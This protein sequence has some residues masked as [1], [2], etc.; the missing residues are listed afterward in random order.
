MFVSKT[1]NDS[2]IDL[3][4]FPASKVS[5]FWEDGVFKDYHY[6]KEVA[7]EPQAAQVN[8]FRHQ[9]TDLPPRKN[10]QKQHSHKPRS[11]SQKR[12]SSEHNHNMPLHKK[13][14]Y[15]SNSHQR[16]DICSKCG[17]SKHI[18]GFKCPAEK[19]Q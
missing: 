2:N 16:R 9:R 13:K 8:L 14:F 1:I 4:K 6:I 5:S 12:C 15:P 18:E 10:K 11:K 7:S 17:H 19:Y 3:E